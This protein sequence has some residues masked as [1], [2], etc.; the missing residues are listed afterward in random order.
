MVASIT[1]LL[2]ALSFASAQAITPPWSFIVIADWHGVEDFALGD[3]PEDY[4]LQQKD[5]LQRIKSTFQGDFVALVGDMVDGEWYR[6]Q[7]IDKFMPRKSPQ[8]SVY[9]A[10]VNCFTSIKKI[11]NEVGHDFVG[12]IF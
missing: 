8:K 4:Y 3:I 11:F 10:S 2:L 12:R 6:Q 9:D 7:W 1:L 5:Q